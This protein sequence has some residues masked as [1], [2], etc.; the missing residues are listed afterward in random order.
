MTLLFSVGCSNNQ[1]QTIPPDSEIVEYLPTAEESYV[2]DSGYYHVVENIEREST[3]DS[4]ICMISGEVKDNTTAIT[5][6]NFD[7]EILLTVDADKMVQT[8]SGSRLNESNFASLIVLK[9]P[10]EVGNTWTFTAQDLSGKKWKVTGEITSVDASG[11]EIVVRHST[12]D[13]YYE[14][15]VLQKG[16]GVTDFLRL[17]IF[18]NETTYTGYHAEQSFVSDAEITSSST[19]SVESV[20]S[21]EAL[22]IPVAYHNLI[23]GFEQAWAGYVKGE[24]EALLEFISEDSPAFKK[25]KA[26]PRDSDTAIEFVRYYPYEMSEEGSVLSI[27]VVEIFKSEEQESIENR[28]IYQIVIEKGIAKIYDFEKITF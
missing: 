25:I 23:L 16:R 15:R 10:I 11:E 19:E 22:K 3:P 27:K 4:E 12:K 5:K 8:Y 9:L 20:E 28:V 26:V 1:T 6:D 13:G 7:F 17:L 14:E 24:N 21:V 2:G 18:K